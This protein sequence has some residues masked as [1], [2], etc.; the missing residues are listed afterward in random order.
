MRNVTWACFDCR[1]AVRRPVVYGRLWA[2]GGHGPDEVRCARCGKPCRYLG[3]RIP[4]PRKD[5]ARGWATLSAR[6][7]E[8]RL[9]TADERYRLLVRS[10]HECEQRI[11]ELSGRP[12]SPDRDRLI[13]E[14]KSIPPDS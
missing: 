13:R 10:R 8:H 9:A 6:I 14:L 5:N 3:E 1:L 7:T 11:R 4:V 12:H 2:V